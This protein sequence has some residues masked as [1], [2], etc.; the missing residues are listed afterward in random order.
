MNVGERIS[1]YRRKSGLTQKE[2]ADRIF[3]SVDLVSKWERGSRRPD[4]GAIIRLSEIFGVEPEAIA[5]EGER[6]TGELKRCIPDNVALKE[7]RDT[8]NAFLKELPERDSNI[9]MLRYYFF[10]DVKSISALTGI[11][12]TNVNVILFRIRKKLK[13][14]YRSK[15]LYQ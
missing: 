10:E 6:M 3:V 9:F 12:V 8:L 7:L 5:N 4:Y 14:Y 2:L 15:I 11:S 13:K 1:E